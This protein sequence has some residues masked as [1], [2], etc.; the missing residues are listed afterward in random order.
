MNKPKR[1]HIVQK[2]YLNNFS[3]KTKKGYF[4]YCFDKQSEEI[5][6]LNVKNVAVEKYFYP[7]EVEKWLA[8]E[9]EAKGITIIKNII[10]NKCID[11]LSISEKE[12][13]IRWILVQDTRTREMRNEIRQVFEGG[14]LLISKTYDPEIMEKY[15]DLKVK[16]N[17]DLLQ[18][19][20]LE[21][22]VEFLRLIPRLMNYKFSLLINKS[23]IQY[24]TADHPIF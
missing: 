3:R 4:L 7:P 15:K 23:N 1:T 8:T 16:F 5:K 13:L 17:E 9:I 22:M 20:Q 10:E 6:Y 24:Y 14:T 18:A 11:N 21:F 19:V 2:A 12:Y